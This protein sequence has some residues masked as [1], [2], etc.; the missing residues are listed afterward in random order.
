VGGRNAVA[1]PVA[2]GGTFDRPRYRPDLA[3]LIQIDPQKTADA[4]LEDPEKGVKDLLNEQKDRIR[5]ILLPGREGK[6][7]PA[8]PA[9]ETAP[10]GSSGPGKDAADKGGETPQEKREPSAEDAV[11]NLLRSL[12]FGN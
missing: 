12:P 5:S 11:R 4:I 2:I 9:R 3:N 1:V 6:E 8:D 7:S 10:S